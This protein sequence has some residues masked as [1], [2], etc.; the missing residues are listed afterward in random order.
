MSAAETGSEIIRGASLN[1][2][3]DVGLVEVDDTEPINMNIS[4]NLSK[5]RSLNQK[6]AYSD[7]HQQ[8]LMSD[9]P[10]SRPLKQI[11][12]IETGSTRGDHKP[13]GENS[14][15]NDFEPDK[16]TIEKGGKGQQILHLAQSA[17]YKETP[18]RSTK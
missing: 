16:P 5:D 15:L 1:S 9:N 13:S 2:G 12:N 10:N 4:V 8:A 11:A 7:P 17:K 3:G 18:Q 6:A 14:V